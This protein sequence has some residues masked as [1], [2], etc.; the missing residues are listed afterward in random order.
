M[1]FSRYVFWIC[2]DSSILYS[3]ENYKNKINK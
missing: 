3:D 2:L 1:I